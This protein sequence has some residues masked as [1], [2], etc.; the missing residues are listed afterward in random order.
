MASQE[1]KGRAFASQRQTGS[2]SALNSL[3]SSAR[4][5]G[6]AKLRLEAKG[7]KSKAYR[8]TRG[9][10]VAGVRRMLAG[11]YGRKLVTT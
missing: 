4:R 1:A 6:I 5:H 11:S 2:M 7:V 3:V 8:D 9:P 10:G